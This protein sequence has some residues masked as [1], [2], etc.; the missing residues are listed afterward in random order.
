[1]YTVTYRALKVWI[2]PHIV[3][4]R[5]PRVDIPLGTKLKFKST[6]KESRRV[7]T[8]VMRELNVGAVQRRQMNVQKTVSHTFALS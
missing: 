6:R 2:Q 5:A 8:S 1:M 7:S 3:P 4:R